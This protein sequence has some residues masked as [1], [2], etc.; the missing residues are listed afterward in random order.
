MEK[1]INSTLTLF[2]III[3]L[4]VFIVISIFILIEDGRPIIFKQ[5]RFGKDM[6]RFDM[7]KFR[8]MKVHKEDDFAVTKENDNRI[9]ITGKFLRRTRLDEIPQLF[10][11]LFGQMAFVGVRPDIYAHIKYYNENQK[12][13]YS[14]YSPGIYGLAAYVYRNEGLILNNVKDK[15]DYY[16]NYLLVEKCKL[17]KICNDNKCFVLDI[18]IL[19]A[20]FNLKKYIKIKGV[21]YKP[22]LFCGKK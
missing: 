11:I 17:N 8:S 4:P 19:L 10:N 21:V 2:L 3:L 6:K 1:I 9:L 18:K 7:Y 16:L 13:E 12:K 22:K 20:S 5:E 14:K 15:K